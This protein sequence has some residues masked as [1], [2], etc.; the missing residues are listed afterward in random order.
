MTK[1]AVTVAPISTGLYVEKRR[2][3]YNLQ[4]L[5]VESLRRDL[6]SNE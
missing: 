1:I 2:I 4:R 6:F 5:S 3:I